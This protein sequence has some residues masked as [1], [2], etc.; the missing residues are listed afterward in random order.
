MT[1]CPKSSLPWLLIKASQ[2]CDRV[3]LWRST[4]DCRHTRLGLLS[5][6]DSTGRACRPALALRV[7]C[8]G[9]GGWSRLSCFPLHTPV[10]QP[11]WASSRR[12]RLREVWV[13]CGCHLLLERVF[14]EAVRLSATYVF[15]CRSHHACWSPGVA[16]IDCGRSTQQARSRNGFTGRPS[17]KT[18]PMVRQCL[19]QRFQQLKEKMRWGDFCSVA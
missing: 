7:W 16:W 3:L 2:C 11:A 13:L 6:E 4:C 1:H 15:H 14:W 8:L 12:R 5:S 10:L 17:L 9:W 19:V 18:A